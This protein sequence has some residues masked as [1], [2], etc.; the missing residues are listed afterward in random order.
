MLTTQLGISVQKQQEFFDCVKQL[1]SFTSHFFLV[2]YCSIYVIMATA[3][4]MIF[5]EQQIDSCLTS[6]VEVVFLLLQSWLI[7]DK[8]ENLQNTTNRMGSIVFCLPWTTKLD[9]YGLINRGKVQSYLLIILRCQRRMD[10]TCG[11]YFDMSMENFSYLS[12]KSVSL[13]MFL[14]SFKK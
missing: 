10:F 9:L 12:R 8:I 1:Q 2:L 4:L 6:M 13:L 14:L 11:G 5:Y 7:C 3:V